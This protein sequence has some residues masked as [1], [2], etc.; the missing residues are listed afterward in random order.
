MQPSGKAGFTLIELLVVI[1]RSVLASLL[2]PFFSRARAKARQADCLPSLRQLSVA[3]TMY[4]N[5][6]D[7]T[8][9]LWSLTG[10]DPAGGG[11]LPGPPSTWDTQLQPYLHNTQILYCRNNPNGRC[12]SY[13][14]PCY[15]SGVSESQ[16][17]RVTEIVYLL[18]KGALCQPWRTWRRSR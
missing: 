3:L 17:T 10:G 4:A 2:M 18:E 9:T 1:A 8:L 7:E 16:L 14:L 11:R 13:A 5:D 6:F 15:V 12:H